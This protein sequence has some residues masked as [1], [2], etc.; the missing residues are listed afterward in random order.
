MSAPAHPSLVDESSSEHRAPDERDLDLREHAEVVG[1][2]I[3]AALE[4]L[5]L[6]MAG[7][8]P[9]PGQ[10]I[11]RTGLDKSLAGRVMQTARTPQPLSVLLKSPAPAGLGIFVRAAQTSG[12]SA[13]SI[14]RMQQAIAD[15][16]RL[17]SRFPRGRSGLEAAI[18]GWM[19]ESR[20]Q[21]E[22]AARQSVFNAMSFL[23][24][25]QTE[26]A[27]GCAILRPNPDGR[28]LDITLV[29]GQ[30]GLRRLREGE[31]MTVFG[32]RSYPLGEAGAAS[33]FHTTLDGRSIEDASCVLDEFCVPRA[34][35]L[36]LVRSNE[37]R[38]FVLPAGTP[39]LNEPI[40]IISAHTHASGWQRFASAE[41]REEWHTM[42]V[43]RP[44][45]LL[46]NDTFIHEDIY[47]GVEPH[48]TTHMVGM[49][50]LPARDRGPGF[51]LDEVRLQVNAG[52][53]GGDLRN[54]GTGDI[55]RHADIVAS[56]FSRI[57]EDPRKY[58]VHRLRMD[59][60]V[61]GMAATRWF[62]LPEA[63]RGSA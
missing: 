45:K 15:F 59:Y 51:P 49:T 44:T 31:A 5:V 23:F 19:P 26:A 35:E 39:D 3:R 28:T 9:R 11:V 63:P 12:A 18:S 57:G 43:R 7:P 21:G 55:P 17:L 1:T 54:L 25:H 27:L 37:Q 58:R 53:I 10:L 36:K 4:E 33:P 52:W 20:E 61:S 8:T 22:R 34:P 42:M 24:G 16:E 56:V 38:L 46:I 14:T 41:R 62:K 48:I 2:N 50:M 13:E 6:G 40:T 32:I 47:P 29:N 60:P 30:I